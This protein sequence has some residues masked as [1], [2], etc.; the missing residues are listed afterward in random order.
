MSDSRPLLFPIQAS[1]AAVHQFFETLR[2]ELGDSVPITIL[3]PGVVKTELTD[4]KVVLPSGEVASPLEGA[5]LRKVT[6]LFDDKLRTFHELVVCV[7][8]IEGSSE[9]LEWPRP[10]KEL[11]G[12]C[13]VGRRL[14][15]PSRFFGD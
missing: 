10:W 12:K 1:K 8:R 13:K 7:F 9:R 3:Y 2:V 6:P 15:V 4:G 11:S 14:T 5:E